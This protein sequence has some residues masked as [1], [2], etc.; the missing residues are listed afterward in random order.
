MLSLFLFRGHRLSCSALYVL[1][2]ACIDLAKT[3]P[4]PK[5]SLVVSKVQFPNQSLNFCGNVPGAVVQRAEG[6]SGGSD[7]RVT[8]AQR[9]SGKA[10][11]RL[12]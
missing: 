2:K 5:A 8:A 12:Y 10:K 6:L 7:C 4:E 11:G 9:L 1:N 3:W